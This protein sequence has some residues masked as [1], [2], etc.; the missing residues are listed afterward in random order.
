MDGG[1]RDEIS[2]SVKT[3]VRVFL[4]RPQDGEVMNVPWC[5]K[6]CLMDQDG[7]GG[8]GLPKTI[9]VS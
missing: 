2:M 7:A 4:A 1:L 9:W 6:I 3:F 5:P 8:R